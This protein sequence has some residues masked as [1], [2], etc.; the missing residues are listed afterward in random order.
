[1]GQDDGEAKDRR[2]MD[3]AICLGMHAAPVT[4][5]REVGKEMP[6]DEKIDLE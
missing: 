6:L 5:D 3:R 1:M 4:L 2:Y